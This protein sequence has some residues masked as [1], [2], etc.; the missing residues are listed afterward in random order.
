MVL[1]YSIKIEQLKILNRFHTLVN[2]FNVNLE[3]HTAAAFALLL[4][5]KVYS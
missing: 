5:F 3:Y 2:S 4:I 1:K